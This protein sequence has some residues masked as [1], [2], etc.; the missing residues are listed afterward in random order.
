[1]KDAVVAIR[2]KDLNDKK[3]AVA[4]TPLSKKKSLKTENITTSEEA[5]KGTKH[6]DNK[7]QGV[8]TTALSK[9]K[10]FTTEKVTTIE[11]V[12]KDTKKLDDMKGSVVTIRMKNLDNFEGQY[13]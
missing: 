2:R 8:V 13:K 7:K 5:D 1:M 11:E 9:K 10:L 12:D 6:L 4:P 3:E